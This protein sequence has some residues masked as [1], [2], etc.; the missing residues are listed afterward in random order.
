MV[1]MGDQSFKFIHLHFARIKEPHLS[2]QVKVTNII[3]FSMVTR[4]L[5]LQI[6]VADQFNATGN[7]KIF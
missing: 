2:V 6:P 1:L 3:Y 7:D 4:K 5:F